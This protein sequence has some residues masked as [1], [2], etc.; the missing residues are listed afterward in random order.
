MPLDAAQVCPS[1][2]LVPV[3]QRGIMRDWLRHKSPAE[4]RQRAIEAANKRWQK[5]HP[6]PRPEDEPEAEVYVEADVAESASQPEKPEATK[7]APPVEHWSPPPLTPQRIRHVNAM[8]RR[9]LRRVRGVVWLVRAFPLPATNC[10]FSLR[11]N[12]V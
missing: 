12:Y 11:G 2:L 9:L 7:Y 5:K 1:M 3:V 8:D 4:R 6:E 10:Q